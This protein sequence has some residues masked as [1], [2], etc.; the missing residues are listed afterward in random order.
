MQKPER[1]FGLLCFKRALNKVGTLLHI[2]NGI[3]YKRYIG[4]LQKSIT[5]VEQEEGLP[6]TFELMQNYPNPFNPTTSISFSI[7]QAAF[8][9]LKVYDIVGREV[10]NLMSEQKDAGIYNYNFDASKLSSG[11]YFY[12]LQAGNFT[13]SKKMILIK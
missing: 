6:T 2:S 4:A 11:I 3:Y 5:A 9:T 12:R 8:V 13:S 1:N 10:A 7:P